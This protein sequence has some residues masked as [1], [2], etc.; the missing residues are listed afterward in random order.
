MLVLDW[1]KKNS[2]N[3]CAEF[4][5]WV[6]PLDKWLF[7]SILITANEPYSL[8]LQMSD[9][10]KA[11]GPASKREFEAFIRALVWKY[12]NQ[13]IFN[14]MSDKIPTEYKGGDRSFAKSSMI[15]RQSKFR[16]CD[17]LCIGW[18]FTKCICRRAVE[19]FGHCN[20]IR[21]FHIF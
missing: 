5:S 3:A 12:L 1:S 4:L 11:S 18:K 2:I 20:F 21:D 15:L 13:T 8:R 6:P 7:G 14:T 17:C 19:I 16:Q 9:A 10:S